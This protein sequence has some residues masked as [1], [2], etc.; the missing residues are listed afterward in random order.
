M[1]RAA[2]CCFCVPMFK[3]GDPHPF[4]DFAPEHQVV[5]AAAAVFENQEDVKAAFKAGA[6]DRDVVVVVRF[7]GPKA[8]GMPELHSL[9]PILKIL[10]G[11]GYKVAL[12]TDGRM[13]G[14]SGSIPAAIHVSPE[15][16]DG[17][18][19]ARIS[20]GDLIL[21]DAPAGRLEILAEGVADRPAIKITHAAAEFSA[22]GYGYVARFRHVLRTA[23]IRLAATDTMAIEP[24]MP[25][26]YR[27]IIFVIAG[28]SQI[29]LRWIVVRKIIRRYSLLSSVNQQIEERLI[30]AA[31]SPYD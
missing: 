2:T 29:F 16:L 25:G 14:A 23:S 7:Q 10:Q 19:I 5:K 15:A 28:S 13:S 31:T 12:V 26:R 3:L 9:T 4:F 18:M 21:V 17:G 30:H 27:G 20:D 24:L 8:N 1:L 11:R 6:L 22:S